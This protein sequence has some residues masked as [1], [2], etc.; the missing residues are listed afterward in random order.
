M[1]RILTFLYFYQ[2]SLFA[3]C[4]AHFVFEIQEFQRTNAPGLQSFV[5]GHYNDYWLLIGGRT[6]GMHEFPD[7]AISLGGFPT[8]YANKNFIVYNPVTDSIWTRA[9]IRI[10]HLQCSNSSVQTNMQAYQKNR[11]HSLSLRRIR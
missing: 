11:K 8:M 6:E 4:T 9:Y 10:F 3:I 5:L 1:K 2:Y 7:V